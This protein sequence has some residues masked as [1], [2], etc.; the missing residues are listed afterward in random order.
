MK[1]LRI[2]SIIPVLT[3]VFLFALP[4]SAADT[5]TYNGY[6][7]YTDME[8]VADVLREAMANRTG[9]ESSSYIQTVTIRY[10]VDQNTYTAAGSEIMTDIWSAAVSHTGV[11]AEGDYLRFLQSYVGTSASSSLTG[12]MVYMTITWTITWNTTAEEEA[13]VREA[14]NA[15]M[16][17]LAL[18]SLDSEYEKVRAIYDY[19]TANITYSS[20]ETLH[21]HTAYAALV[22]GSAVCQGYALAFYQLAL[23]AGLDARIIDGTGISS[24]GSGSHAWNIV[25]IDGAYYYLDATWDDTV[26]RNG[27]NDYIYFLVGSENTTFSES[28]ITASDNESNNS[29]STIVSTYNISEKDYTRIGADGGTSVISGI[30]S[31]SGIKNSLQKLQLYTVLQRLYTA[32]QNFLSF[33][34]SKI[35][36]WFTLLS[37]SSSLS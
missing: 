10:A 19:L 13:A 32:I 21:S 29:S 5:V 22:E 30:S 33:L 6:A 24:S 12:G 15:I 14:V 23:A 16:D 9:Q 8:D 26:S 27:Y 18:D 1:K 25:Q 28:H 35:S 3:L 11:A 7:Y 37:I 36:S 4:I 2:L 17:N 20:D 34:W 31:L